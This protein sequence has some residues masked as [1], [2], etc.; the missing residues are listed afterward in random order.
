MLKRTITQL[1]KTLVEDEQVA[2]LFLSS[3]F[4]EEKLAQEKFE[5]ISIFVASFK[6]SRDQYQVQL[7]SYWTKLESV[8][9][10]DHAEIEKVQNWMDE[11]MLLRRKVAAVERK[12]EMLEKRINSQG[13]DENLMQS[14]QYLKLEKSVETLLQ[15]HAETQQQTGELLRQVATKAVDKSNRENLSSAIRLPKLEMSTFDGNVMLF[16]EFWDMFTAAI[17][18][19]KNLSDTEKLTYLKESVVGKAR[20]VLQGLSITAPNYRVAVELLTER[21]GDKQ[22][23]INAHYA[24]MLALSVTDNQTTSLRDFYDEIEKHMRALAAVGEDI[25][26]PIFISLITSKLPKQTMLQLEMKRGK[27]P[28]SVKLLRESLSNY[29]SA[30]EATDRQSVSVSKHNDQERARTGTSGARHETSSAQSLVLNAKVHKPPKCWYCQES[31]FTDECKKFF[32]LESRKQKVQG[33]CFICLR[34]GH[35][36]PSCPDPWGCFHCKKKTHHRSLCPT[37]FS[38]NITTSLLTSETARQ[39]NE[40]TSLVS[41][42]QQ[43]VMQTAVATLKGEHN[44]E[45]E[46]RFLFDT[47]SSR[48]FVTK[49]MQQQLKLKP[50]GVDSVALAAFGDTKRKIVQYP[51]V[52]LTVQF[53]D[54]TT[55]Q[56]VASVTDSITCPIRRFPLDSKQ[57]PK[58]KGVVL[59][60]MPIE[61][62]VAVTIDVLIG[63]D[64]YYE[65]IKKERVVLSSN[66]ILL[67]SKFGYIPTGRLEQSSEN[68]QHVMTAIGETI[69][70]GTEYDLQRFWELEHIGMLDECTRS[71]ADIAYANFEQ[72]VRFEGGRYV[73]SWPWKNDEVKPS[74]TYD[75]AMGRLCSLVK[76]VTKTPKVMKLYDEVIQEQLKRGIIEKVDES[77]A[78]KTEGH[79]LPH[80][81]VVKEGS[82]T[83]K[84]RIVFDA[85]AKPRDTARSLNE[86]LFKGPNLLPDLCGILVRFRLK[87]I[88]IMSDVEKAFLQIGLEKT[89]RDVTRFLWLKDIDDPV[90]SS[91]VITYRF[92]RIPFGVIASPFLLTATVNHHLNQMGGTLSEDIQRN[93]YVDNVVMGKESVKEAQTYYAQAKS[94]FKEA[95]MN[96][97]TWASNSQE[98]LSE[99]PEADLV[100]S[101]TQSCLGVKWDTQE[102]TLRVPQINATDHVVHTKRGI[103]QVVSKFYDPI[104]FHSPIVVQAKQ[105]LQE[106][107]KMDVGWDTDLPEPILS[108]WRTLAES[109][110]AASDVRIPRYT[111]LPASGEM[112]RELHLFC[113]ASV[114][115]YGVVAYLREE[116]VE[117]CNT[118]FL[119]SKTRVAPIK[120]QTVPRLE[121]MAALIGTRT[122]RFLREELPFELTRICLWSDST[123]VLGWITNNKKHPVFVQN[124]VDEIRTVRDVEYLYVSTNDNPADFPSRGSSVSTSLTENLWWQGPAWLRKSV[125]NWPQTQQTEVDVHLVQ[126]EGS[127][128][129]PCC[130]DHSRFS[131]FSKMIRVTAYVKKFVKKLQKKE[132]V[133][134]EFLTTNELQEAENLWLRYAQ[135]SDYGEIFNA[136]RLG[137]KNDMVNKLG[138]AVD[139]KGLIRCHGRMKNATIPINAKYPILLASNNV[140][141]AM[142]I[143]ECHQRLW[144]AGTSQTL[145]AVRKKFWITRGRE[146]VKKVLKRCQTCIRHEGGPFKMPAMAPLPKSRVT[147]SPPF[148]TTGLDYFGPMNAKTEQGCSKVWVALF[149]CLST[150]AVH[151]EV[152]PNMSTD[153][154]LMAFRRFISR[155]GTPSHIVSDNAKQFKLAN[156]TLG[157]LWKSTINDVDVMNYVSNA[158]VKWSFITELSP[159]KGGIYERMVQLVKRSLRKGLGKSL[160][161]VYELETALIEI[162]AVLN[163][164]PLTY[165]G[166]ELNGS[167]LTPSHFLC[168]SPCVGIPQTDVD[169]TDPEFLPDVSS[170]EVLIQKLKTGQRQLNS[171]WKQWSSEYLSCLRERGGNQLHQPRIQSSSE[172]AVG[173]VVLIKEE[174][175]PRGTWQMGL[176]AKLH[177]GSDDA[178][179]SATVK[180]PSGKC[181]QRSLCHLY[182]LECGEVTTSNNIANKT[183][184]VSTRLASTDRPVRQSALRSRQALQDHIAEGA[185]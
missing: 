27:E 123:C 33:K 102:D 92:C 37:K 95:S 75:L 169:L 118:C 63:N 59:A 35:I 21:F 142:I 173:S 91:N 154:F 139:D 163:A 23:A 80:H 153:A 125:E 52:K 136:I 61:K 145:I 114:K 19:N 38:S 30:K 162:E 155:R 40:D 88:G 119:L 103:L 184:N 49:E 168:L 22:T 89:D 73:V 71:D 28:W 111:S 96:L 172:P 5:E 157:A 68:A 105:L 174:Y 13:K 178:T 113:D 132:N 77:N 54:Q 135:Q 17:H 115:S 147:Q 93:T 97:R 14:N 18:T 7:E 165:V 138:L 121:L 76:R 166:D 171:F 158:G 8:S 134:T 180:L 131:S 175:A 127:L 144:H 41:N 51:R 110:D 78:I 12:L 82:E 87:P 65:F 55:Q 1:T 25:S 177:Q 107:W 112:K 156:S 106:I 117:Q 84:L 161:T 6:D 11:S 130:I 98:F 101:R 44:T 140:L 81:C 69:P 83:T 179:R 129:T 151:L 181:L 85:S 9:K 36:A 159:W 90:T 50:I 47:G 70:A 32:S 152:V 128:E 64:V 60:E 176:I 182:P 185:V 10:K 31:H 53:P 170:G 104:G 120:T 74:N 15:I 150:R 167:V 24:K 26:Q 45:A 133:E 126:G 160:L 109:L 43:V 3:T 62:P 39:I 67:N 148:H 34:E 29:V 100:E 56:V 137:M 146:T 141:S 86:C 72:N 20:E 99:L 57:Y 79:Y 143:N 16:Q 164:R 42:T 108:Q 116:S 66:L 4:T 122:I 124:R 2:S 149:T 58:L 183:P 46:A 48:T 94:T